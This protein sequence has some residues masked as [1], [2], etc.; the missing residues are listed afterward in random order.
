[1]DKKQ[2]ERLTS[3]DQQPFCPVFIREKADD[4]QVTGQTSADDQS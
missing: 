1:V 3:Y 2:R 4:Q